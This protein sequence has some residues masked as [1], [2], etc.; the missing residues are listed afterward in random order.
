MTMRIMADV[1]KVINPNVLRIMKRAHEILRRELERCAAHPSSIRDVEA[2]EKGW[3]EAMTE[4]LKHPL[5][6]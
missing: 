3:E 6:D 1:D 4:R 5:G 2:I